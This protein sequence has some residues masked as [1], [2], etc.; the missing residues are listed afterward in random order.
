MDAN[1]N[2]ASAVGTGLSDSR[3]RRI[4]AVRGLALLTAA[5]VALFAATPPL[6]AQVPPPPAAGATWTTSAGTVQGTRFSALNQINTTNVARLTQEFE[7]KTGIE[8]GHEGAPLVVGNTMYMVG[9]FPNK[10]FALNLANKGALKWV[11][12]PRAD[13]FAEGKACC[14]IVNRGAAYA[15]HPAHPDGLIIYAVLDTTVVAVNARTG[16]E[17]WRRKVGKVEIGETM[18]VAPLV[19]GDK[20]IVGN[21]GGEFGVRGFTIGLNVADGSVAWKAFNTGPD[22]EVLIQ[23]E[24]RPFYP[25]DQGPN[26]GVTTWPGDQWQIGGGTSWMGLTY[27]PQLDLLFHGTSNP[28][29]WN[30]EARPGANKWTSTVFARRPSTGEAI[31]AYQI[32]PHDAHDYDG[33]NENIVVDLPIGGVTRKVTVRFDRN[34]F[35]YVQDARTGQVLSAPK[36]F[37]PTNWAT[38]VNLTTGI[39]QRV[40]A[41]QPRTGVKVTDI[42]PYLIGGKDQ[43]PA[44]FSP[45][46]N[47]FY[48]PGNRL[49]MTWESLHVNYIEGTP[50][51]GAFTEGTP[52][53]PG[54]EGEFFAWDATTGTKA[55]RIPERFPVW[56]GALATAGDVVFYG[57]MDRFFKAVDARTGAVLFQ[58]ELDSGIVGYPMTFRGADGRQ[59]VAVYSGSG[60]SLVPHTE[61][62]TALDDSSGSGGSGSGSGDEL[63][64]PNPL[65]E[66]VKE[67]R[68]HVF[69]L[70]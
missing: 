17:V 56:S 22:A 50:F 57:T 64:P 46:T 33:T 12:N 55:W 20:V 14:D 18:T 49:C 29:P 51:M 68:V 54:S 13:P 39:P 60:G 52:V 19:V 36:Y 58:T 11:F 65:R 28:G 15:T 69:V 1:Q 47:L 70:N 32:T 35:A 31:W 62:G 7:F 61:F 34:G 27:D 6:N 16:R 25:K 9:P 23:D 2:P 26:L 43:Q 41:K 40:E 66:F 3:P 53:T 24:F 30:H 59:R 8:A 48:V 63:V 10:L 38:E 37:E 4:A 67:G 5:G 21:S 44:A 45:R 42:C